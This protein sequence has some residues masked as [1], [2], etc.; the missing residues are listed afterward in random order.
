MG[1]SSQGAAAA[2]MAR[3]KEGLGSEAPIAPNAAQAALPPPRQ[4]GIWCEYR[5]D[6]NKGLGGI[7]TLPK[8]LPRSLVMILDWCL[9]TSVLSHVKCWFVWCF[10]PH[11]TAVTLCNLPIYEILF[12]VR[13]TVPRPSTHGAALGKHGPRP[14]CGGWHRAPAIIQK[15]RF[16]L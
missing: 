4:A 1:T 15:S 11:Y 14:L 3:I 12:G 6:G 16:I 8:R 10:D 13:W 5:V 9:H 7:F 2:I